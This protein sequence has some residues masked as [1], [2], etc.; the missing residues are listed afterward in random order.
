[1]SSRTLVLIAEG[2]EDS[3]G[4]H[5]LVEIT[6]AME[7]FKE[8]AE[9]LYAKHRKTTETGGDEVEYLDGDALVKELLLHPSVTKASFVECY[10]PTFPESGRMRIGGSIELSGERI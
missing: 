2:S 10:F 1:M 6:L 4:V 8:L 7:E 3:Y 5:A 9:E